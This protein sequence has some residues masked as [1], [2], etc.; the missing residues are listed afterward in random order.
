[1]AATSAPPRVWRLPLGAD[2]AGVE[3]SYRLAMTTVRHQ[4]L[5]NEAADLL[6]DLI[7]G[8]AGADKERRVELRVAHVK[9]VRS[10]EAGKRVADADY[11]GVVLTPDQRAA[12]LAP[13]GRPPQLQVWDGPIPLTLVWS[14]YDPDTRPVAA[15]G[16][17][18]LWLRPALEGQYLRSLARVG[19]IQL[20]AS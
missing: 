14:V 17:Q 20:A 12:L 10:W 7:P 4:V 15:E 11:G 13:A 5:A 8:Y 3:I 9:A 18:I 16:C 6:D 1:M 2:P 19:H